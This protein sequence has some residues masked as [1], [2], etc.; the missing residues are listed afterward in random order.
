MSTKTSIEFNLKSKFVQL[1]ANRIDFVDRNPIPGDTGLVIHFIVN[2]INSTPLYGVSLIAQI[3]TIK[4]L[5][6]SHN[7]Y[8]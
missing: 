5:Y 4:T 7:K 8:V 1:L 3:S 2:A 6:Q